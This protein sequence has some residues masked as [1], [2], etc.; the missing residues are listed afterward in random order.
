MDTSDI[1]SATLAGLT[2]I[3]IIVALT[4]GIN[5]I[6]KTQQ[7]QVREN[8]QRLLKEII[9]WAISI[10]ECGRTPD[11]AFELRV[12]KAEKT[13]RAIDKAILTDFRY[14]L[15]SITAKNSYI[16][17]ISPGINSY[18]FLGVRA[19][20]A[21]LHQHQR[22]IDLVYDGKAKGDAVGTHRTRLDVSVIKL[23]E[24]AVDISSSD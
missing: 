10:I 12:Q 3:G 11:I 9:D 7:L 19:T 16:M 1:I 6:R 17:S 20:I 15:N 14:R 2:L 4:L 18:L 24:T 21:L 13:Q 8:R 23:I 22:I 5:S